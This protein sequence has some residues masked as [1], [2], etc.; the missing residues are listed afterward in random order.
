MLN[1]YEEQLVNSISA[2]TG[3]DKDIIIAVFQAN[4]LIAFQSAEDGKDKDK[5]KIDIP[6][7]G[8]LRIS[9]NMDSTNNYQLK[10][11]EEFDYAMR[12]QLNGK[13]NS[14]ISMLEEGLEDIDKK[15]SLKQFSMVLTEDELLDLGL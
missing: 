13:S 4:Y 11:K 15:D 10:I 2:I 3:L 12:Q 7:I 14:F 6:F 5:A 8:T 9:N 1:E